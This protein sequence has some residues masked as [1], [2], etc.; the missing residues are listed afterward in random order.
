MCCKF[1]GDADLCSLGAE[2][3]ILNGHSSSDIAGGLTDQ[4]YK[5]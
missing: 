3:G 5:V 1:K 2:E 4:V